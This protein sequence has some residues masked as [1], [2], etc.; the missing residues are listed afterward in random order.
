MK[1]VGLQ[2]YSVGGDMARSVP[3]TL[4]RVAE[5]G[6]SQVEFAGYFGVDAKEMTRML[7]EYGLEAVSSHANVVGNLDAELEYMNTVGAHN[8]ACAGI[9]DFNSRDNVLR[10][11]ELFN[12]IGA[13]CESE[14]IH[15]SYHNHA[16]EFARDE[17]GKWLLDDLYENTDPALVHVQ[18]DVCW[19]TV[20]GA[21]PVEYLR[22]YQTRVKSV[23][24]KEVKTVAPYDGPAIGEGIV[25]FKGIY[26]LFGDNAIYIVEQEGLRDMETW[27]GLRRSV[28][29]LKKL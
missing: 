26:G 8:I 7:D 15:F 14:G 17:Q 22:K 18:L 24:M 23:H 10:I 25:D 12:R 13:R 1:K 4:K 6:Y 16:H 20:G 9:G 29:Y 3:E 21:D 27:E 28:E 11:A 5:L 2:L 19:A